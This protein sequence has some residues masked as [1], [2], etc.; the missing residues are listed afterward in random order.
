MCIRF[1]DLARWLMVSFLAVSGLAA[2]DT[3]LRL[4]DAAENR[5]R[6][7]VRSLLKE[8]VDV[9]A[10]QADGVTA[11]AWAVH[12]DDLEMADLLIHAGADLNASNDYG[13]TPLALAC[14]NNNAVMVENLLK[15][16]ANADASIWTGETV[17]MRC[18]STGNLMTV[19]SLLVHG[20][21]VNASESRRGQTAL[22]WAVAEKHSEIAQVL[23][24]SG[25]NVNAKTHNLPGVKQ[26]QHKS[27]FWDVSEAIDDSGADS[28]NRPNVS[29]VHLDPSSSK[30]DFTPLLFAAQQGDLESARLLVAA[31]A[32]V[33][34]ISPD[35][36][37]L[38]VA[39]A[40]GHEE[41]AIYLLENGA[42]P[43]M[44]DSYGIAPLHYALW[45][46]FLGIG[47]GRPY[48]TDQFWLR[49]NMPELVKALLAHGANPNSRV[50]TGFPPYNYPP[51]RRHGSFQLPQI[52]HRGA[53]PFFVAAASAD[54]GIMRDLLVAGADPHLATEE[55]ATPLMVAAGL[56]RRTDRT[57]EKSES[58]LEA[59]KLLVKHGA[60]V[61][62][63][64][65]GGRTALQGAAYMGEDKIIQ[66]L[67]DQGADLNAKD[68]Y[69][70][71]ALKIAEGDP[72]RS[73]GIFNKRWIQVPR[74]RENTA[75]LLLQLGATPVTPPETEGPLSDPS[76][77]ARDLDR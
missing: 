33:N 77:S 45:E 68:N 37:P 22:M 67:V 52:I 50:V 51:L 11:L 55:G 4:V 60:D 61:N 53:T 39:S 73:I 41:L 72:Q 65:A 74:V 58:A 40:S 76:A 23:I 62:A 34:H 32:D 7:A 25:A 71:T 10:A 6:K 66:F 48:P 42:D 17:L 5:D 27:Y 1:E 54:V 35:G 69:G 49:T 14:T 26:L 64:E 18:V 2:A 43:N 13:V 30:G 15:A 63:V 29:G 24:E 8:H 56:G 19:K 38:L 47:D 36:T 3:D 16:G 12:W 28:T 20:A 59:V 9:N 44:A 31:G 57:K 75:R 70:R 46:G 21:D